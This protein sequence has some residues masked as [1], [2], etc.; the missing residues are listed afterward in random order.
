MSNVID[1]SHGHFAHCESG[2]IS[3][4]LGHHGLSLSEPM[5]FGL[6]N[7]LSFAFLPFMR[8]G[9]MPLISY[10]MF[11]GY[12]IK[13]LPKWLGI[14]YF[15][16]RYRSPDK[17][18]AGLDE[19]LAQGQVV[20][21][22]T[23]AYFTTYFP[24]DMRFQF[25]AH[26]S[27]VFG[28]QGDEYLI[29]D[30]VFDTPQRIHAED[31]K[32]ARFAKG[33]GAPKGLVHFPL[34]VP[35]QVELEPV[36]RASIRKTVNMMLHA[37]PFIGLKGIHRLARHVVKLPRKR[38]KV[39]TRHFLGHMVRMQEE[40]GT[41]GGGFRFIYAAFLHEVYQMLGNPLLLEASQKMTLSGDTWREFALACA[42]A[43]KSRN[44]DG[45]DLPL[46]AGLLQRCAEAEKDVFLLLKA[47]P[48]RS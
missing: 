46:I 29:S 21:I 26:N 38:D 8:F 27:I 47:L 44:G 31:L 14:S 17:A 13:R 33:L 7:A 34:D 37:P 5:V 32:K 10:R 48:K 19:Y 2:V 41:G 28:K 45:T 22:Q 25:N 39:Y 12:I 6:G 18:M 4:L 23:S 35:A 11:P 15:R 24:P 43:V 42:R 20:G 9:N 36:I 3:S 40:I 1:Y 30:P 16:R